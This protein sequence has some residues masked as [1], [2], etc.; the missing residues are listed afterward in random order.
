MDIKKIV[1]KMNID[2]LCSQVLAHDIQNKDTN[3]ETK[4]VIDKDNPGALYVSQVE[5]RTI[6]ELVDKAK[7]DKE[8]RDYATKKSGYPTLMTT[9]AE[10]GPGSF[11]KPLPEMPNPMAW[12]ACN[13]EKLI[14][15]AG[16]LTG[17]ILRKYGINH[18]L[19]PVVDLNINFE[20]PLVGIRS[21]S[22]DPNRVIRIAGAYIRGVQKKGY[23]GAC[24]KHFPGDGLDDRNQHFLTTV[25]SY[26]KSKWMKT[27]GKVYKALFRQGVMS[28]M[29]GHISCPAFQENETDVYGSLPGSISKNLITGLLK[30]TLGFKG[31]VI[32]DAMSMIGVCAR[33]PTERLGVAFFNAGGDLMLFPEDG[34]KERLVNAVKNGE[35]PLE[36]IKDAATRVLEMKE[37]LRLFENQNE[38][39]TEIGNVDKDIDRLY[40]LSQEIADKAVKIVRNY[41]NVLPV[42]KQTGKV[43]LINLTGHFFD[44][45]PDG[46]EFRVIENEFRSYGWEVTSLYNPRHREVEKIMNE[47]DLVVVETLITYHGSTLRVGWN[48]FMALWRGFILHH[49][50]IVFLSLDDPYKLYD[51][52]YA[53]TYI[54]TFGDAEVLQKSAVKLIL[55]KIESKGKNPVTFKGY[56]TRED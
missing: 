31:C 38:I 40:L 26:S 32:S 47:Y 21:I 51:F 42:T 53:K 14:E 12:G 15:S 35:I 5:Y 46:T 9:D 2:E 49:P 50:N 28:V 3:V 11:S 24:L 33:V 48:N 23:V 4:T 7:S 43:L 30:G 17:R 27:Y 18:I 55:G 36:R 34:E 29:V 8:W 25:N 19:A 54:N 16:E 22:D 10:Y 6:R 13:D 37:R 56:F 52:P 20:N 44:L 45:T 39:E 1:D 41:D